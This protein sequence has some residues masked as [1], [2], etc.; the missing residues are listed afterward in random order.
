MRLIRRQSCNDDSKRVGAPS[1]KAH[2]HR[3]KSS[4]EPCTGQWFR[5]VLVWSLS[6]L[7]PGTLIFQVAGASLPRSKATTILRRKEMDGK[8]DGPLTRPASS[9]MDLPGYVYP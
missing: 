1:L 7:S 8:C 4:T 5:G 3:H 6:V 9:G 2:K